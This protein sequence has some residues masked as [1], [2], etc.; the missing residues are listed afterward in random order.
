MK[1]LLGFFFYAFCS[2]K[3]IHL[4]NFS[5]HCLFAAPSSNNGFIYAKIFGGFDKI[6]SSVCISLL[7]NLRFLFVF[8]VMHLDNVFANF[9]DM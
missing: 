9:L 7:D 1:S 5:W 6:R 2:F 4:V 3:S 8:S